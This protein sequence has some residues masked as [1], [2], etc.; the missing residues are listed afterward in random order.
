MI[1]WQSEPLAGQS[2]LLSL[3]TLA[4]PALLPE[5]QSDPGSRL[6]FH[7]QWAGWLPDALFDLR[8][9]SSRG[10]HTQQPQPVPQYCHRPG[11]ASPSQLIAMWALFAVI[12]WRTVVSTTDHRSTT[13]DPYRSLVGVAALS[14]VVILVH[15]LAETP[16]TARVWSFC[17]FP[18]PLRSRQTESPPA[19][20]LRLGAG[21]AVDLFGSAP[22]TDALAAPNHPVDGILESG[23]RASKPG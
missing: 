20:T 10:F 22:G 16:C 9:A 4:Q 23:E 21:C 6:P 15:G 18:W 13:R 8:D 14:L 17:F 3:D 1:L 19:R 11:F 12:A 7:R 5:Q 2:T